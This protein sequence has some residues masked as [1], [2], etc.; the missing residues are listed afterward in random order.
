[1]SN[2][3]ALTKNFGAL[4]IIQ[5]ANFFVPFITLP[6][7]VRIIGP[8]K[9]GLLNFLNAIVTYFILFINYGFDYS[10]T[11]TVAQNIRNPAAINEIFTRSFYAKIF[12][13]SISSFFFIVLLFAIPELQ[14][15]IRVSLLC[16]AACIANIF[17]PNWLFQGMGQLKNAAIFNLITKILFSVSLVLVIHSEAD[18]WLYAFL[19]TVSQILVAIVLFFYAI[20]RFHIQF[21]KVDF[22]SILQQLRDDRIVFLSTIVISLYTTTNI[23]I[24]GFLKS[25]V[26]VGIYT[27]AWRIVTIL[28]TLTLI[29]LSQTIYPHIGQA[30]GRSEKEG[31]LQVKKLFPIVICFTL[32]ISVLLFLFAPLIVTILFGKAFSASVILLRIM[33]F[34]PFIVSLS[35]LM[36]IQTLLNLKNDRDFLYVTATGS[37]FCLIINLL[38]TPRFSYYGTVVAWVLTEIFISAGMAFMLRKRNITLIDRQYFN[39]DYIFSVFK[40]FKIALSKKFRPT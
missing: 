15:D 18:Y 31:I 34:I 7:I 25:T 13:F 2:S 24:L 21:V 35:N 4:S 30:F 8:D 39:R 36:G 26:E 11:R 27:A 33:A 29:P 6:I 5:A 20:H 23:V 37:V 28:N 19:T 14:K 3:K 12:L 32:G 40:S 10:A 9:F 38:L 17:F 22:K 1:M 16:F